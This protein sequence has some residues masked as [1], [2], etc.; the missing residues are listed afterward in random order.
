MPLVLAGSDV[1]TDEFTT[2][3]EAAAAASDLA[4]GPGELMSLLLKRR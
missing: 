4:I 2:F 3:D 1:G